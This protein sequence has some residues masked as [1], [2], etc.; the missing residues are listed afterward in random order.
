MMTPVL[1]D[2]EPEDKRGKLTGDFLRMLVI[3]VQDFCECRVIVQQFTQQFYLTIFQ[4][5]G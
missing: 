5:H 2:E 3:V 4:N 1:A